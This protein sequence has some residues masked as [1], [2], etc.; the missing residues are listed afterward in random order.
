MFTAI[1]EL[2]K[3]LSRGDAMTIIP[4]AGD[5]SGNLQGRILRFE[6]PLDRE[7]YDA[8]LNRL[9]ER[10]NN[11]L[12]SLE[13]ESADRPALYTD[14]LGSLTVA[15]EELHGELKGRAVTVF[16]FSDF[17]EDDR[18]FTFRTDKA[19]RTV[20][21]ARALAERLA[22]GTAVLSRTHVFCGELRSSEWLRLDQERRA[23]VREFWI[24]YLTAI[25]GKVS[26]AV[27]GPAIAVRDLR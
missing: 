10:M 14:I 4:V 9:R 21:T 15:S 25:G 8:D 18:K 22:A 5:A 17:L 24:A 19:L 26:F 2:T 1:R 11:S 6:V 3:E 23:A 16:I 27:D 7:P 20:P 13:R 12:A